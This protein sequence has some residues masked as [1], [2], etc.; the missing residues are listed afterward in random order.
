MDVA[1]GDGAAPDGGTGGGVRAPASGGDAPGGDAPESDSIRPNKAAVRRI[2]K[3]YMVTIAT[4]NATS[5]I[6][7]KRWNGS[8]PKIVPGS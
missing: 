5:N 2:L 1:E 8:T 4:A 3:K 6:I 7:V